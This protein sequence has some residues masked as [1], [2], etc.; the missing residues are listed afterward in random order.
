MRPLLAAALLLLCGCAPRL[1]FR[2]H[3]SRD[4]QLK[5]ASLIFI[6]VIQGHHYESWP[7]FRFTHPAGD[8][9]GILRREVTV[10]TILRG[11]EPRKKIDLFEIYW[12]GGRGGDWNTTNDG[13]RYLFLVRM[14][15]G[16]YHVVGDWYRSIFPV[17]SGRR[18]RLPLDESHS[19]WERIALMN[20]WLEPSD[21]MVGMDYHD[22]GDALSLW[23]QT[24]LLRGLVRH[25]S[26]KV[27]VTACYELLQFSDMGQ[28][29][30]WDALSEGEREQVATYSLSCCNANEVM[31]RRRGL[32]MAASQWWSR[33]KE[34]DL[35]R[36]MTAIND[37]RLRREFCK[38]FAGEY[39]DDYDNGCPADRAPPATIVTEQG[40]VPLPD[41]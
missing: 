23:R 38:L 41:R 7:S 29:E 27:R 11:T 14:E 8:S 16:R 24:K 3:A 18:G 6:G 12:M 2:E 39:P 5:Q 15:G 20:W 13:G 10:E 9:W 22:P 17:T 31:S 34:L 4:E 37:R 30:C 21:Y 40:D 1:V 35:R 33:R 19:L 25:P 28:D 26:S 32:A 36:V